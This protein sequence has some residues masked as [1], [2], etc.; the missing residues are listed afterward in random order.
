MRHKARI[1]FNTVVHTMS[2]GAGISL[3]SGPAEGRSRHLVTGEEEREEEEE[4]DVSYSSGDSDRYESAQS[5]GAS[6]SEVVDATATMEVLTYCMES[7]PLVVLQVTNT[8]RSPP[9]VTT[10]CLLHRVSHLPSLL[11]PPSV[12]WMTQACLEH[13]SPH[14]PLLPAASLSWPGALEAHQGD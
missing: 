8:E 3:V 7:D 5:E 12:I 11:P 2:S 9:E 13:L 10:C 14:S 6:M 1:Y 4:G